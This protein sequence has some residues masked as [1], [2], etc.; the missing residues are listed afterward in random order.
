MTSKASQS[1]LHHYFRFRSSSLIQLTKVKINL[2]PNQLY[3]SQLAYESLMK[4]HDTDLIYTNLPGTI[5]LLNSV[6]FMW[7]I[8]VVT[9]GVFCWVAIKLWHL[10]SLPKY[11][12]KER[13]MQQAKLVFW[14][15][16]LGLFWK[17]LW[18]LA[19]IAIVTDW[20]KVQQWIRGTRA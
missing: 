12:A 19:V 5:G 7:V 4:I 8:T 1:A 2:I 16:M 17:P 10:H 18:V 3:P 20:D 6:A 15:C 13:G 9:V 11:L 14:L